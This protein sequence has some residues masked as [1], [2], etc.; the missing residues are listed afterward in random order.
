M[1]DYS[2]EKMLQRIK[3]LKKEKGI[4]NEKLARSTGISLGTLSK[5]LAGV[6]KEPSIE[7]I[8]KISTALETSADYII[9]GNKTMNW[10]NNSDISLYLAL[11]NTDRAEIRGTMKQ[12]LKADKYKQDIHI[13]PKKK[14]YSDIYTRSEDYDDDDDVRIAAH[15]KVSIPPIIDDEGY[16]T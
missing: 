12:M 15:K 14:S 8:I 2:L 6:T 10:S 16:H 5:I 7:S 13:V 3:S 11:D 1:N 9:L 4:T